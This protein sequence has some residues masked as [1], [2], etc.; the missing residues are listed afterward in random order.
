VPE[1]AGEGISRRTFIQV[2][3]AHGRPLR[4][5]GDGLRIAVVVFVALEGCLYIFGGHESGVVAEGIDPAAQ[6]VGANTSLHA[7]QAA[8]E[9][10]KPSIELP[11]R[12]SLTLT[13]RFDRPLRLARD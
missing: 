13:S 10:C 4:R 8:R 3:L 5:F 7:D 1:R 12:A 9:V 6:V 11:A 2:E